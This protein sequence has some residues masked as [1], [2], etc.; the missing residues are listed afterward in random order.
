ML[1]FNA[2]RPALDSKT[3]RRALL[4]GLDRAGI[5]QREL[6]GA[7]DIPGCQ[8]LSGPFSPGLT[9]DD[10]LGYACD[11]RIVPR[12]Y[13]PS[14]AMV[15]TSL[16][17]METT[18]QSKAARPVALTDLVLAHPDHEIARVASSAIVANLQRIG[19]NCRAR[20]LPPGATTVA[21][22]DWDLLYVDAVIQDPFADTPRLFGQQ[23]IVSGSSQL[24]QAIRN[25]QHARSWEEARERLRVIHRIFYDELPVIALWQIVDHCAYRPELEGLGDDPVSLYQNVRQWHVAD[26]ASVGWRSN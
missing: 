18:R 4:Y 25:L 19:I 9:A 8:V 16:A 5:L 22:D 3:F 2:A 6:L 10:P 24:T 13:D 14:L 21:D 12:E 23:G 15:L 7:N 20:E 1:V 26:A 17:K 11:P